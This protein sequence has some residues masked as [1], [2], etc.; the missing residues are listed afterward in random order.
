MRDKD[1]S[2]WFQLPEPFLQKESFEKYDN[3]SFH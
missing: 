1:K 2:Y 3:I